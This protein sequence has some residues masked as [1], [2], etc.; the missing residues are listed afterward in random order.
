MSTGQ[1]YKLL[2]QQV[3]ERAAAR[4]KNHRRRWLRTVP[5][6]ET[7]LSSVLGTACLCLAITVLAVNLIAML[8]GSVP[9]WTERHEILKSTYSSNGIYT[10]LPV[11]VVDRVVYVPAARC[12]VLGLIG[13]VVGGGGVAVGWRRGRLAW[14]SAI[15]LAIISAIMLIEF[16]RQIP[17]LLR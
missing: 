16:M 5:P 2:V 9:S 10:P 8:G 4:G 13:I 7:V 14:L 15:G 12:R 17:Y 1:S 11:M 3:H 6:G